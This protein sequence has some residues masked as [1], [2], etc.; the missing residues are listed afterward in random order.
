MRGQLVSLVVVLFAWTGA[1]DGCDS[2]CRGSQSAGSK[3][4]AEP[5]A[6]EET[7]P[8]HDPD[9]KAC[10]RLLVVGHEGS[11]APSGTDRSAEAAARRAEEL[12]RR[13]VEGEEAFAELAASSSDALAVASGSI[14]VHTYGSWPARYAE[15]RD[16]VFDLDVDEVTPVME[17]KLGYVI[18]TRCPVGAVH[19][20]HILIRYE[21]A[22]QAPG[23]VE[24]SK[25][26]ARRLAEKLLDRIEGG[27]DLAELA[28]E[29]SE[30]TNTAPKGGDLGEVGTGYPWPEFV[31]V[32]FALEPGEIS[33]VVETRFGYHIIQR[34]R[35]EPGPSEP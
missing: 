20:R 13:L 11:E 4:E 32:A 28:R 27:E 7:T 10:A 33:D 26:E 6:E 2:A 31:E 17:T 3:P 14:G 24:R 16:A 9:E 19:L 1:C 5:S 29:H 21:G 8:E 35:S 23:D 18:A 15:I 12:R 25:E 22:F 34:P 30:D